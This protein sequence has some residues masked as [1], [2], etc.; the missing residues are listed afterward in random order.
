MNLGSRSALSAAAVAVALAI[1][2]CGDD[3]PNPEPAAATAPAVT[4]GAPPGGDAAALVPADISKI[5][6]ALYAFKEA[7]LKIDD[8]RTRQE[9]CA[10]MGCTGRIV[11][12]QVS[13]TSYPTASDAKGK[14]ARTVGRYT[15]TFSRTHGVTESVER[16]YLRVA[17]TTLK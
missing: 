17:R 14:G 8:P 15:L 13:V 11:T 6:E 12:D 2:G 1:A 4:T 16:Q 5:R 3:E 7:G 10:D 9:V